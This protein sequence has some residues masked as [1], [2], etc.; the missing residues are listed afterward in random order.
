MFGTEGFGGTG[1][2]MNNVFAA[3]SKMAPDWDPTPVLAQLQNPPPQAQGI[4][5]G[6]WDW[7]SPQ[8]GVPIPGDPT[9]VQTGP[10][11]GVTLPTPPA[12]GAAKKTAAPLTPQQLAALQQPKAPQMPNAPAVAPQ[13]GAS[14]IQFAP[15]AM[16]AAPQRMLS[17]AEILGMR[18]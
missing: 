18:R 15:V 5:P 7:M 8:T 3:I 13:R 10:L 17:L 12:A 1:F 4:M 16:G 6:E 11:A 9:K 14:N 2:D